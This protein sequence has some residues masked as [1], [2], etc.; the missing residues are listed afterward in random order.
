[1]R[2]GLLRCADE[3][4]GRCHA[5]DWRRPGATLG[6]P[7]NGPA[8]QRA[9]LSPVAP[10]YLGAEIAAVRE[11]S[12]PLWILGRPDLVDGDALSWAEQPAES[13]LMSTLPA[14][15][16]SQLPGSPRSDCQAASKA[17]PSVRFGQPAGMSALAAT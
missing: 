5:F 17:P 2:R 11:R 9:R 8:S 13:K 16:R 7:D 4:G 15:P 10:L 6:Q 3:M 14:A 12:S 1:M